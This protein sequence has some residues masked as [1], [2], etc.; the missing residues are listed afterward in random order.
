MVPRA[1]RVYALNRDVHLVQ[2]FVPLLLIATSS[3]LRVCGVSERVK[4]AKASETQNVNVIHDAIP[5][6]AMYLT[7]IDGRRK[8]ARKG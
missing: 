2:A 8:N 1:V 4:R 3:K 6:G 5:L 7:A